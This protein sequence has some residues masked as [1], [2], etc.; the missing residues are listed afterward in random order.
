MANP[1]QTS[2]TEFS[3]F[4]IFRIIAKW[5]VQTARNMRVPKRQPHGF[6]GLDA[7]DT[8]S[9]DPMHPLEGLGGARCSWTKQS[10]GRTGVKPLVLEHT[11]DQCDSTIGEVV[12]GLLKYRTP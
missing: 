10:I 9:S 12:S 3:T 6:A 11:L 1:D 2:E 7:H 5:R 4:R 8:V